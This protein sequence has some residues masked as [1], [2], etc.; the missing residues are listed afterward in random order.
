MNDKVA[1][2]F[3]KKVLKM[4]D[5]PLPGAVNIRTRTREHSLEWH[6][7]DRNKFK[8]KLSSLPEM[9]K[10]SLQN[11][12]AEF[13]K[14]FSQ[15]PAAQ[16]A[17]YAGMLRI[18]YAEDTLFGQKELADLQ[19]E[20]PELFETAKFVKEFALQLTPNV[21]GTSRG[22]TVEK[23]VGSKN[24]MSIFGYAYQKLAERGLDYH[25][26]QKRNSVPREIHENVTGKN[27]PN[28]INGTFQ[29]VPVGNGFSIAIVNENGTTLVFDPNVKTNEIVQ[30]KFF[31]QPIIMNRSAIYASPI[32]QVL[33]D[34]E[35]V[36]AE[37]NPQTNN[38]IYVKN[39]D[40]IIKQNE[41]HARFIWGIFFDSTTGAFYLQKKKRYGA[42]GR[43]AIDKETG[44][45]KER[46]MGEKLYLNEEQVISLCNRDT[47]GKTYRVK[48]TSDNEAIDDVDI[49]NGY[50]YFYTVED[51]NTLQKIYNP[52]NREE[53]KFSIP[54]LKQLKSWLD[55][56]SARTEFDD[57]GNIIETKGQARTALEGFILYMAGPD[58]SAG[59]NVDTAKTIGSERMMQYKDLPEG[60][61]ES[62]GPSVVAKRLTFVVVHKQVSVPRML[63]ADRYYENK[64]TGEQKI[65]GTPWRTIRKDLPS[66]KS[67]VEEMKSLI[68][69]TGGK[70]VEDQSGAIIEKDFVPRLA[71]ESRGVARADQAFKQFLQNQ[72]PQIEQQKQP[73][74][75][76]VNTVQNIDEREENKTANLIKGI[77]RRYN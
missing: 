25:V 7:F 40:Q 18:A 65:I 38:L 20:R 58:F 62:F 52:Q 13:D 24:W 8:Q 10:T 48:S 49:A 60:E 28:S 27:Y 43:A 59:R 35:V 70:I 77:L 33:T 4:A 67:A 32:D 51:E 54:A 30:R 44:Q 53:Y 1:K 2:S 45:K 63:A 64:R 75:I 5:M 9:V 42:G 57:Q 17:E 14:S 34:E 68:A 71:P 46:V 73:E 3:I 29:V 61:V 31:N 50:K 6:I 22:A 26:A 11:M 39:A 36:T 47:Y 16:S 72:P 55:Q 69:G 74:Q 56:R 21:V 41:S 23:G 66:L 37:F 15:Y 19:N 76:A 12:I